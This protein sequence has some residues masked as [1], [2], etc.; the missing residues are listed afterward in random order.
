MTPTGPSLSGRWSEGDLDSLF[1]I[2]MLPDGDFVGEGCMG[3]V[4]EETTSRWSA[5]DRKAA[6]TY[7]RSLPPIRNRVK[8]ETSARDDDAW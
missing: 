7:I 4:V 5:A 3:E 6:I 1:S 2:G 8:K